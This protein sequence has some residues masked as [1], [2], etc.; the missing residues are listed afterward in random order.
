MPP[1]QQKRNGADAARRF[2][3]LGEKWHGG[4]DLLRGHVEVQ[5]WKHIARLVFI[6]RRAALRRQHVDGEREITFKCN[7][8]RNVLDVR[9]ESAVFV[10]DDDRGALTFGFRPR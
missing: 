9:I 8:A 10:N 1:P 5:C 6:G 7:A 2:L 4:G 3:M